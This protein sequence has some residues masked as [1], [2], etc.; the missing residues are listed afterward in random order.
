M[1]YLYGIFAEKRWA[2]ATN[3]REAL[4]IAKREKAE[5]RRLQD[6]P[7]VTAYDRP[8]FYALSLPIAD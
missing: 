6:C 4:K 3:K 1:A 2:M 5:V 7:E 8:T